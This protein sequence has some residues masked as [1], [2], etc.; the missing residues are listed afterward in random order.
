MLRQ[1]L[2]FFLNFS[3]LSLNSQAQYVPE[4]TP[5]SDTTVVYASS[6]KGKEESKSGFDWSKVN[7][8]GNFAFN[9]GNVNFLEISPVAGYPLNEKL[10]VGAGVSYISFWGQGS[11][12]SFSWSY[13]GG[14][15]FGRHRLFDQVFAHAELEML[16]VPYY[17]PNGSDVQRKWITS[18]LV[19]LGYFF[20]F[21]QRGGIQAT[22][23]YNTNYQPAYSPYPSDLIWRMGFFF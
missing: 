22:L 14:R 7:G 17:L 19:G 16:N 6:G 21:S 15:L 12:G 5:K 4:N 3:L 20:P 13:F 11:N 8:G 1:F 10:M 9:F 2:F 18:P 23:L